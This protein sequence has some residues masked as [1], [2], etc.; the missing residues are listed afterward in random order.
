MAG[1]DDGFGG[2]RGGWRGRQG[3]PYDRGFRGPGGMPQGGRPGYGAYGGGDWGREY[4]A[5]SGQG[6][7]MHGGGNFGGG[8]YGSG[9]APS[10]RGWGGGEGGYRASGHGFG[11]GNRSA[12]TGLGSGG[13]SGGFGMGSGNRSG[14]FGAGSGNRSYSGGMSGGGTPGGWTYRAGM[15][16]GAGEAWGGGRGEYGGAY[17]EYGGYPGGP[18]RGEYYGGGR[19]SQ[20]RGY[21]AGFA[22]EP[23]MPEEAY[24]RHPEYRQERHPR[25]W[26]AHQHEY[27]DDDLSDDEIREAVY[28]RMHAD[29]WLEPGRIEVQVEDGVVTLTGEVDDFLKARYA[30][31]DA[32][33]ADGVR[34]VVNNLTVR[35]DEPNEEPH[36]DVVTQSGGDRT[37]PDDAGGMS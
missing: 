19:P 36:G 37:S 18:V 29:A 13:R 16:R 12:G 34:G 6:R 20:G 15:D 23:F 7:P 17:E 28:D 32:W 10:G 22:R 11:S 27:G 31:D 30:W 8:T 3:G 4:G 2:P 5:G 24:R 14:G 33:E 25:D 21:D 35:A 26:E 1:Y 9:G